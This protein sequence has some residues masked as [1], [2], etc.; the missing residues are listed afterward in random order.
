MKSLFQAF[1][2]AWVDLLH[3]KMLMLL[4]IPPL[5]ALIFWGVLGYVF[6]DELLVLSGGFSEK[7]LFAKEIP[8]WMSE[9]F[10]VTPESVATGL[11]I[12]IAVLFLIPMTVLTSMLITSIVAMPIVLNYMRKYFPQLERKGRGALRASIRNLIIS[13][14]IYLVL[15]I[16]SLPFWM[17]PG[18][19]IAIPL[20]LN[21]YLNYRLFVF[22]ALADYASPREMKVLLNRKRVDF[23][24][25]G[26][27]VSA[28]VL[29]P[30]MFLIFPIYSALCFS[31]YSLLQLQDLRKS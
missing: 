30:P 20:L 9:W 3:P 4:F 17:I 7:F 18:L 29:F 1:F 15:W 16:V 5:V 22:D 25:L 24:I 21:G 13:S 26:V 23:L 14:V 6:W 28:L 8:P 2:R 31:R 11:A 10:S 27:I 19:G 12:I